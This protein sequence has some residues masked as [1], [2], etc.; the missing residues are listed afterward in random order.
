V[1][2][3]GMRP[4]RLNAAGLYR[5]FRLLRTLKPDVLQT[6]LYHA[7]LA[8]LLAG[9]LARV[10]AIAW[11]IRCA[12]L[13]PRDH[14]ATLPLL[15]RALA[16]ASRRPS[17]VV[18]NSAAGLRAHEQLGYRPRRWAIIP[19]GF[20]TERYKPCGTARRDFRREIGVGDDVPL[21]G[22]VARAHPMK[23]HA[24]FLAAAAIVAARR[25]DA[26]F[27]AAGRGVPESAAIAGLVT[28][29]GLGGRAHLLDERHDTWRV[30]A[31]LDVAVSSSYS[32]AFPNVVGE[33]MACGTSAVVT[34]VGDSAL[35]V[36]AAGR[37]VPPRDPKALAEAIV[38]LLSMETA[39]RQ[40][41]GVAGRARIIE[42]YSIS[43][44]A[45]RYLR[46][47]GE[48]TG[49]IDRQEHVSCAG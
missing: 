39:A 18:S 40:T 41:L 2:S 22:L 37:V 27:V 24:T 26:Q 4:G 11:N 12:A 43:A 10:P 5:A 15:L 32:E 19:N 1:I 7:D 21:V 36:G 8:G 29:L 34:D 33:A 35:I 25:P 13:D 49:R 3:L 6:W 46:L 16:W 38:E 23:D 44:I 14:P 47:Y 20:D 48:L 45:S 9:T 30:L 42:E 28:R 31:A 17:A